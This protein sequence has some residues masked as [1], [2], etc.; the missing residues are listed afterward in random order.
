MCGGFFLF[1]SLH[2][3]SI[4]NGQQGISYNVK[5]LCDGGEIEAEKI[6]LLL[7]FNQGTNDQ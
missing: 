7:M 6:N 1:F 4:G 5:R 3:A 2:G